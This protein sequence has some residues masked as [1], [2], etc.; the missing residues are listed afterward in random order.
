MSEALLRSEYIS[1][2]SQLELLDYDLRLVDDLTDRLIV[3][4]SWVARDSTGLEAGSA[5]F[6]L[7]SVEGIDFG[8][9]LLGLTV[10]VRDRTG[11]APPVAYRLGNWVPRPPGRTLDHTALI[12]VE[13]SDAVS[14]LSTVIGRSWSVEA[15]TNVGTAV[16]VLLREQGLAGL[17][18]GLPPIPFETANAPSWA[19]LD[20]RTWL[21]VANELL[22]AASHTGLFTDQ[23]GT[24]TALPYVPLA[25]LPVEWRFDS[26]DPTSWV[27]AAS[28][29]EPETEPVPNVWVGVATGPD[30]SIAGR[31]VETENAEP[32]S[33]WSIPAQGGRRVVR[34]LEIEAASLAALRSAVEAAAE[35]DTLRAARVRLE[36]GPLPHLWHAAAVRVHAPELDLVN[37]A[38]VVREWRLPLDPA[39]Q[40]AYYLVDVG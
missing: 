12:R 19:L 8:R 15:G 28:Q 5:V 17:S 33:P 22:G 37:K 14:L 10:T 20:Q 29:V 4:G 16:G 25:D 18:V 30:S 7:Q 39:R 27:A 1:L 26:T 36:C 35:R 23:R 6:I 24:L 2:D 3:E 38:G 32:S 9:H 34:V 13:C 21:E 11:R 40:D 31:R